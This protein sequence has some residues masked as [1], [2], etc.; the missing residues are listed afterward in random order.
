MT[1]KLLGQTSLFGGVL[2]FVSKS[3]YAWLRHTLKNLPP[4][5]I[6]EK[7][8][9]TSGTFVL[10]PRGYSFHI[11]CFGNLST[12][13]FVICILKA[14]L[15]GEICWS[16]LIMHKGYWRTKEKLNKFAIV[17]WK[18]RSHV[19]ISISRTWSTMRQMERFLIQS[20]VINIF[21][22]GK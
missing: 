22:C 19:R 18:H 8:S 21:I 7:F 10:F 12:I 16:D 11:C 20:V 17:S 6:G 4:S 5:P 9:Q 1:P 15:G 3:L 14:R 13:K 2:V